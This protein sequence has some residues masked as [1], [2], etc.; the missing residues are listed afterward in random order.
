MNE[1][2]DYHRD[3][4]PGFII[5]QASK[6]ITD[7]LHNN[8]KQNEQLITPEQWIVLDELWLRD[9]LSQ[10]DI[11]KATFRDQA[12]TSRILNNLAKRGLIFRQQDPRDKRSNLVYLT[13]RGKGLQK[14]LISIV[15]ATMDDA[16]K[17]IDAKELAL[18]L[19]VLKQI[20]ANIL[21]S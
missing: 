14:A 5:S 6:S 1:R 16:V 18:C 21:K 3:E 11:A 20:T 4:L 15:T 10:L 9:G 7:L 13:D 2:I 12:S 8:F 19:R 17:G